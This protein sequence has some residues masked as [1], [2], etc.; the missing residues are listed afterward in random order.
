MKKILLVLESRASYGYSKNLIQIL[1]KDKKFKIKTVVT[2][3]H[4]SKELGYSVKNLETDNI[5]IDYKL[6]FDNKNLVNGIGNLIVSSNKVI[7]NFKPNIVLIFGDRVEL[8][9]FAIACS[10]RNDVL[11]AH[12][13]A[14]D[15]SG[16][17]DDMTRM[18]LAKLSHIHFP[19]TKIA[20]KRLIKLGEQKKR[21]FL[22]GAPQLDDINYKELSKI[23]HLKIGKKFYN[24]KNEKYFVLL[25]HPVFKNQKKYLSLFKKTI[26]AS[27]KFNKK[28]FI[29]YPNYDPGYKPILKFLKNQKNKKKFIIIKNLE[30]QKFLVL[31]LNSYCLIGNSSAGLLESPSLKIPVVNI[32]DRQ[33]Y[34][35]QNNNI[36]NAKYTTQ[37][38]YKKIS[39]AQKMKNKLKNIKNIHGDGKSSKRIYQV[40]KKIR[41]NQFFLNKDT[42]Y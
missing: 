12:V 3:T 37:D 10:Y 13:Q 27:S 24:L 20:K 11:L 4:L 33:I 41:I 40:L 26:D 1:E 38:I 14:G 7:N 23:D 18:A 28:I 2:G 15:R 8:I 5:K 25:Q 17:I 19:A 9:P 32:G 29:I 34:R 21:I 31:V 35:E 6:H 36:L 42:T 39:K 16:H 22:V 30:R